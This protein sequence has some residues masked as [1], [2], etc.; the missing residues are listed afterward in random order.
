MGAG[1]GIDVGDD[2]GSN[3]MDGR[4]VGALDGLRVNMVEAIASNED[5]AAIEEVTFN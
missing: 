1:T 4:D 2:V 5:I 3:D